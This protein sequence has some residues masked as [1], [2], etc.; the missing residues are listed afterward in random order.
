[1]S[2]TT[3]T[4]NCDAKRARVEELRRQGEAQQAPHLPRGPKIKLG[5]FTAGTLALRTYFKWL[6]GLFI[7]IGV[8][9]VAM[10]LTDNPKVSAIAF[11][12]MVYLPI[13]PAFLR[14]WRL[15]RGK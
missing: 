8:P 12:V 1:M 9:L 13:L 11:N 4:A 6:A 3:Y 10:K 15:V 14:W 5:P 7:V 2:P